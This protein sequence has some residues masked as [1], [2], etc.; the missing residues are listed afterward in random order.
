MVP[1]AH[2]SLPDKRHVDRFVRFRRAHY[3]EQQT[4]RQTTLRGDVSSN[5]PVCQCLQCWR[6]GVTDVYR[7]YSKTLRAMRSLR[8]AGNGPLLIIN[9]PSCYLQL[10]PNSHNKGYNLLTLHYNLNCSAVVVS[11]VAVS[12]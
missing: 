2:S 3:R 11:V 12:Y 4:H 9:R 10:S 5:S 7:C 1:L 6:R 8:L